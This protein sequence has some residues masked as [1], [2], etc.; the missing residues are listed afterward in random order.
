MGTQRCEPGME[1]GG[2]KKQAC[3]GGGGPRQ[4]AG[5][6][7][8]KEKKQKTLPT[9]TSLLRRGRHEKRDFL[10]S[11]F[12]TM[13]PPT[14]QRSILDRRPLLK[15]AFPRRGSFTGTGKLGLGPVEGPVELWI[16]LKS[17]MTRITRKILEKDEHSPVRGGTR[18]ELKCE[19]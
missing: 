8:E 18:S 12:D 1:S 11:K 14:H 17:G 6:N 4:A 19:G 15:R 5:N 16:L 3:G 2:R 10:P 13:E 7:P 9:G